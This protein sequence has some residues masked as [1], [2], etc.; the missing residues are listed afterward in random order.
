MC[1]FRRSPGPYAQKDD[2]K[3]VCMTTTNLRDYLIKLKPGRIEDSLE[4]KRLLAES[5]DSLAGYNETGMADYKVE[6]V[7]NLEWQPPNLTFEMERHGGA[8][9]GSTRGELQCWTV[10][11]DRRQAECVPIGHRQLK[12]INKRL[13]AAPLAAEIRR[14]IVSG[15]DDERLKWSSDRTTVQVLTPAFV[16]GKFK[17][18]EQARRK[19]F[20]R[21]LEEEL[22]AVG[23]TAVSR[24]VFASPAGNES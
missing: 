17:Q 15:L 20:R 10:N 2:A 22:A 21:A 23:W 13:D 8:V 19:R 24:D 18:T 9:M 11:V 5:W 16:K 6:R 7:E 14:C 12:P 3:G 1:G 4:L